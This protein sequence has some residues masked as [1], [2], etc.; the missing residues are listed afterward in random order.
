MRR[1]ESGGTRHRAV[2][3]QRVCVLLAGC[4][5]GV[6][7]WRGLRLLRRA[8]SLAHP[9]AKLVEALRGGRLR[10]GRLRGSRLVLFGSRLRGSRLVL[11]WQGL[12]ARLAAALERRWRRGARWRL[13]RRLV[14]GRA[15]GG[16][17]FDR[18]GFDH[19]RILGLWRGL[20]L[21]GTSIGWSGD[22]RGGD[23][24]GDGGGGGSSGRSA[25]GRASHPMA[26]GRAATAL[27]RTRR[28][29]RGRG[30]LRHLV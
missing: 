25:D 6:T 21:D 7:W 3:I 14:S 17:L 19:S 13:L 23:D 28:S 5:L 22:H 26:D 12:G 20:D 9:T 4:R 11:F 29:G 27:R 10:G 1:G 16:L 24:G 15:G 30:L 18:G 8:A 2:L